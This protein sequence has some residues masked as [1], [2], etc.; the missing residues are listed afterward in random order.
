MTSEFRQPQNITLEEVDPKESKGYI[1]EDRM[2]YEHFGHD[3]GQPSSN[4]IPKH[5]GLCETLNE[6]TSP[7]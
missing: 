6:R 3:A 4:Y 5:S 1:I 2:A 7:I